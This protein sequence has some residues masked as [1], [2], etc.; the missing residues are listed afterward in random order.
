MKLESLLTQKDRVA[1]LKDK[2]EQI[3]AESDVWL[4]KKSHGVHSV[5]LNA[6]AGDL[7]GGRYLDLGCG[8]GRLAIMA[9]HLAERALGVDFS[10][11]AI[12]LARLC[13]QA[14]G[15]KN[16]E[17]QVGDLVRF[18][19]G[20]A[21]PFDVVSMVGVLEHVPDPQD[22]LARV[23]GLLKPGGL[24]VVSCPNFVNFR[25]ATYMTLL[26]LFDLPMS[27]A[28]LWQIDREHIAAWCPAAGLRLT[29]TLGAIYRFAWGDKSAADMQKR[30][31]LAVRDKGLPMPVD[32]PAYNRWLDRMTGFNQELLDWLR[33]QGVLKPIVKPVQIAVAP[34]ADL[35]DGLREKITL[36]LEEDITSDPYW[37]E[38][39]PWSTLGGEG[40]Y[41]LRKPA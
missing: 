2:Y 27:L 30:V 41:L 35:P 24:L 9:S 26:S 38:T 16:I 8:A 17:F 23:A 29:K 28:D 13:A 37:C 39:P 22:T 36:Y 3:Y 6:M 14:S 31:P 4:Y 33:G 1:G 21:E 15:R 10:A 32:Y 34:D 20:Y 40:V 18:C 11:A 12:D 19:D 7:K 5:I 25:G